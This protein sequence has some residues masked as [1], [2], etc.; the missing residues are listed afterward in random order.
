M[1]KTLSRPQRWVNIT[2]EAK[3]LISQLEDKLSELRSLAEEYE[4]WRDNLPE[5]L[6]DS[7]TADLLNELVDESE[8]WF[9][10]V[11]ASLGELES[12][13]DTIEDANLPRGFG[14][15]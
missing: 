4:E 6:Q 5:S 9:Y 1:A 7:A 10:D 8:T 3:D 15:D 13:F 11:E 12:Q 2:S 14:R